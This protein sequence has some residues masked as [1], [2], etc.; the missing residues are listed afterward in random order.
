MNSVIATAILAATLF[1]GGAT[2]AEVGPLVPALG[3]CQAST[4]EVPQP[5]WLLPLCPGS[6][7]PDDEHCRNLCPNAVTALCVGGVC[8][9]TYVPPPPPPPG[10]CPLDGFCIDDSHCVFFGGAVTG[11]C[12]N[13]S[14]VC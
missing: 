2:A 4:A 8:Q 13:G 10:N 7:C 1:A 14:C 9:Y 3:T 6:F 5:Q 11:T 12:I